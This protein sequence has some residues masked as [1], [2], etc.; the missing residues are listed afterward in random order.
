MSAGSDVGMERHRRR[1]PVARPTAV[2]YYGEAG[3]RLMPG[4]TNDG[5]VGMNSSS[6]EEQPLPEAERQE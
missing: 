6:S 5:N 3:R 1:Q 4:A 2:D